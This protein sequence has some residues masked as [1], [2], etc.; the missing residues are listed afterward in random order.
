[1]NQRISATPSALL[2]QL[3]A[4]LVGGFATIA[5]LLSVVGLYGVTAFSVSQRTRE[6]GVRMAL[7]AQPTAVYRL[8]M[9]EAGWLTAIGIVVGLLGSIAAGKLLRTL[10]FHVQPWDI[11]TL[12]GVI[13]LLGLV[14]LIASYLPAYR[15]AHTNPVQ[16]LQTE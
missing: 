4:W 7:G 14:A 8:I 3:S 11:P 2:R 12:L 9:K 16:A 15:A 10:L 6:I 13:F 1:M 5:L